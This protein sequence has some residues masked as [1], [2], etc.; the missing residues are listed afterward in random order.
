M[1]TLRQ[2]PFALLQND[3]V[4]AQVRATNLIGTGPYSAATASGTTIST[5]PLKPPTTPSE[6]ANTDDTQLHIV[7]DA[8]AGDDTGGE[9][10]TVYS[11]WWDGGVGSWVP[12]IIQSGTFTYSYTQTSGVTAGQPYD[13]KYRASNK[14]GT[15]VFSDVA[16]VIASTVPDQLSPATTANSGVNIIAT[17]SLSPS[18]RGATVTAY[19]VT[20]KKAD[21]TYGELAACDGSDATVLANRACSVA[22]ASL[23]DPST[24]ALALGADV[25]VVVEALNAKGY[26]TP[27][28]DGGGAVVQTPPTAGPTAARGS[29]TDSS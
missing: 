13:F 8:L 11:V 9:P 25:F 7:W 5:E 24:F 10:I 21:G 23:T 19:R 15:G 20:W 2:T 14:H 3:E 26:S 12:F 16:T 27:S 17:W 18:D 4:K 28:A 1:V 29:A 6:G 22:V